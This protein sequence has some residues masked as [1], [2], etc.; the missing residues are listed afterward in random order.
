MNNTKNQFFTV[1]AF[2]TSKKIRGLH[3]LIACSHFINQK[4]NLNDETLIIRLEFLHARKLILIKISNDEIPITEPRRIGNSL[5]TELIVPHISTDNFFQ[6]EILDRLVLENIENSKYMIYIFS[7]STYLQIA[8][9][10]RHYDII[11]SGGSV[12]KRHMLSPLQLR[13][14]RFII[15]KDGHNDSSVVESFHK[16]DGIGSRVG[17]D[18]T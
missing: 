2:S 1:V 9:A 11:I 16:A 17:R 12:T 13:L 8:N 6:K 3:Y 14:S 10:F 15:G 18:L 7:N 5:E 4:P